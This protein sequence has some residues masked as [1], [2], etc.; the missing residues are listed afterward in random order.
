MPDLKHVLF[1]CTGNTCRSPMAEGL[2]RKEVSDRSDFTVSSAGTSASKGAPCNP[3]TAVLLMKRGVSLD[4]FGSRPVTD[5]ILSQ[6]THVFAMTLG[7]LQSLESH[8]PQHADKFYLVCEFAD[9]ANDGMCTDI[10]DPIG[11]G[12]HAYEQVAKSFDIAIPT[13]VAYIDQTWNTQK[14]SPS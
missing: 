4:G 8:F 11:L 3:E 2:F 7:H 13:I 10:P 5:A 12:R 1:V 14:T 9:S 6:A